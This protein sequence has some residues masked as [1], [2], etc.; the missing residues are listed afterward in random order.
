MTLD[1]LGKIKLLIV[2]DDE[3]NRQLVISLMSQVSSI[4]FLEAEDG[5][6]ALEVLEKSEIDMVLLDLHMPNLNGYDTLL[7]IKKEP[8]Y[9]YIP[10]VI[11]TTDEQEKRKLYELGADDFLSK[12]YKLYELESR[13]YFHIEQQRKEKSKEALEQSEKVPETS[14][15]I[16]P[17]PSEESTES[18]ESCSLASVEKSQK[19]FFYNISKMAIASE[20]EQ[21]NVKVVEQLTKKLAELVGYGKKIANDIA[22]ASVVR[23]MG[24][25]SFKERTPRLQYAFSTKAQKEYE[26]YMAVSYNLLSLN[27]ETGF[28]KIAKKIVIQQREHFDGSG[29]PRQRHGDQ[30]HNVVYIVALVETFNALLSQKDF[31]QHKIHSYEETYKILEE[32]SGQRLH[33]KMTKLFLNHFEYFVEI[34]ERIIN[35]PI[36]INSNKEIIKY[37]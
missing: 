33:P 14:T 26:K 21:L 19:D 16:R 35:Q 20:A 9:K 32:F 37:A 22:A 27:I 24:A 31:Y 36:N 13:I 28:V 3:F 25:L 8:K 5:V 4:E 23:N 30:I 29:F 2:D 34:R 1:K 17:E 11:L 18:L 12:P 7:E 15:K 6:G 10:V